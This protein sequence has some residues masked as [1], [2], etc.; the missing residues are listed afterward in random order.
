MRQLQRP[1]TQP[2][3]AAWRSNFLSLP[4]RGSICCPFSST[5]RHLASEDAARPSPEPEPH[6]ESQ[7]QRP[8]LFAELFPD[9]AKQRA[10]LQSRPPASDLPTNATENQPPRTLSP[11]PHS[12]HPLISYYEDSSHHPAAASAQRCTVV[13]SAT[14]K[15]LVESDFY[16]VGSGRAA[17]VE[18]WVG[19]I[20][21]VTQARD[22]HT[23]EP[24]GRYYVGFE[25]AAAAA[26]WREEV[27]RLHELSKLYTPGVV[28]RREPKG[29]ADFQVGRPLN[30]KGAETTADTAKDW[31]GGGVEELEAVRREVEGFTLVPPGVRWD[32][33]VAK[34]TAEERAMEHAGSLVDKLCRKAGTKYLVMIV[35]GGGRLSHGALRK[36]IRSDG[37]ERGLPWRVK[38]LEAKPGDGRWGIMPFGKSVLKAQERAHD[39]AAGNET[40]T[41]AGEAWSEARR[42]ARFLVPFLDEPEARRFVRNWHR[43]QLTLKMGHRDADVQGVKEWEETRLLNVT[44]LW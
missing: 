42:Y 41:H 31:D 20:T 33:E 21:K 29:T 1:L 35:V 44:L 39:T 3:A 19:G 16:R 27:K 12:A 24:L 5:P 11:L 18:G 8:S 15:H 25:T 34:Y 38:N 28:R 43:R 26:A 23:L 37:A 30:V 6:P 14:S 9:E 36:A 13:L 7:Q 10:R 40:D 32:L 17:H 2:I 22:L 4:V